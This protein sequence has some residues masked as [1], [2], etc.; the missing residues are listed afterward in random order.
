MKTKEEKAAYMR[1]YRRKRAELAK[2]DKDAKR[3]MEHELEMN[4]ERIR[5]T[6]NELKKDPEEYAKFKKRRVKH[7]TDFYRNLVNKAL[8]DGDVK[9]MKKYKKRKEYMRG[10][11][12]KIR[13]R[14]NLEK[15]SKNIKSE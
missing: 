5:K 9:A 3:R 7:S 1:E 13:D 14:E 6:I 15:Q 11:S 12:Q 10:V 4:R 2:T 8:L